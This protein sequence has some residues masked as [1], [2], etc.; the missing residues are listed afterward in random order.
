MKE[1]FKTTLIGGALF[2][3]PIVLVMVILGHALRLAVKVAQPI[4]HSLHLDQLGKMTGIGVVTLLAVGLLI[5]VSFGAGIVARTGLG[6][7]ISGWFA[8]SFLG[9]LPQYQVVKSMAEGLSEVKGENGDLKPVLVSIADGWQIG[10]L[11][12]PLENGWL[13]V[14]LPKAPTP[15]S[16]DVKYLPADR[17]RPLNLTMLQ[18]MEIVKH[19][20]IGSGGRFA[21]WTSARP[22]GQC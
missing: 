7:R 15:T 14:F 6:S 19:L 8:N 17:V 3:L 11:L 22:A 12:E 5:L 4:S 20:G 9:N 18:A 2:L 1:F 21:A 10:Y 16:G 13:A